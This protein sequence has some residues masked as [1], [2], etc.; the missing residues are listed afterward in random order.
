MNELERL[1]Q[2]N[3]RL[4]VALRRATREIASLNEDVERREQ[5]HEREIAQLKKELVRQ[6]P[7]ERFPPLARELAQKAQAWKRGFQAP[8][9]LVSHIK[10]L[11]AVA[12]CDSKALQA[13]VH[14]GTRG[15]R[16]AAATVATRALSVL[17]GKP[18]PKRRGTRGA[19]RL[20]T[21]PTISHS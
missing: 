7:A 20:A 13:A 21:V 5:R 17:L 9:A 6:R 14:P 19:M 12:K 8:D 1:R 11:A 16:K 3:E 4:T 18:I 10:A 15:P 2:E